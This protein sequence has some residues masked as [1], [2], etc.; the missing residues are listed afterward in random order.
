MGVKLISASGG[1]VE[2]VAPAT[3]SDFTATM[4]AGTGT[5]AVQGAS[6]NIVSDTAQTAPPTTPQ[7]FDFTGIPSWVKKVTV[8]WNGVSTNG[9]SNP[10][11]QLGDS[12]GIEATGYLGAASNMA[13]GVATLNFTTGFGVF[14]TS[15]WT[16]ARVVYG[17]LII[18]K[19]DGNTWVASGTWA[20]S[21]DNQIG[22]TSGAKALSDT[23]TQVRI[24]TL[25]GTN[26]FDAGTINIL[27]E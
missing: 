13:T 22:V 6:T 3:A 27:Y 5:V 15:G 10:I 9:T 18:S 24:T 23:L 16:A 26:T 2:V 21:D 20:A 8:L 17:G 7:Y 11:I 25:G 12:G 1:S 4:P 19:I 14:G